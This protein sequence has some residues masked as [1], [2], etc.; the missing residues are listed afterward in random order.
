M[1]I[2]GNALSVLALKANIYVTTRPGA[3]VTFKKGSTTMGTLTADGSGHCNLEVLIPNFGSWTVTSTT[4]SDT[5]SAS[6]T[7]SDTIQ[8]NVTVAQRK[9]LI[10]NGNFIVSGHKVVGKSTSA[11]EDY[12]DYIWLATDKNLNPDN[13]VISGYFTA[14]IDMGYWKTMYIDSQQ[15]G[16]GAYAG[17]TTSTSA[18]EASFTNSVQLCGQRTSYDSRSTKSL[19]ISSVTG[20]KYIA[21]KVGS[22][23]YI[24]SG[25]IQGSYGV[26]RVWNLYLQG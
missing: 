10:Q 5:G 1:A 20:T 26:I 21:L 8:Y 2:I 22:W 4:G 25:G 14:G 23:V 24:D 18:Q 7:V 17:L 3:T 16:D 9:Y 15:R 19:N 13:N 6:V 11:F 12:G